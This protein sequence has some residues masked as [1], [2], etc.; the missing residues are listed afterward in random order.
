MSYGWIACIFLLL[1]V[2]HPSWDHINASS[3]SSYFELSPLWFNS[4]LMFITECCIVA[5]FWVIHLWEDNFGE[6]WSYI[7]AW[8]DFL[9]LCENWN[10]RMSSIWPSHYYTWACCVLNFAALWLMS[11]LSFSCENFWVICISHSLFGKCSKSFVSS[12]VLVSVLLED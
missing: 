6:I 8:Y 12:L 2:W 10:W 1:S 5:L 4:N 7:C 9:K 3:S 11:K